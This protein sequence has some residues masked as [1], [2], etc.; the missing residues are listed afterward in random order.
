MFSDENACIRLVCAFI[1]W[2]GSAS[3]RIEEQGLTGVW[4]NTGGQLPRRRR[5][6]A[7]AIQEGSLNNQAAATEAATAATAAAATA[8]A[9][10]ATAAAATAAT[11]AKPKP[12]KG[13][14]DKKLAWSRPVE[15]EVFDFFG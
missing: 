14:G 1:L 7:A 10:A 12:E 6:S 2:F 11:A 13:T 9:T 5:L 3:K 4:V 8:A 15:D